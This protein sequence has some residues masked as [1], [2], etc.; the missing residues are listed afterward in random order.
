MTA[1]Q[2]IT[3]QHQL[4]QGTF[5]DI[6]AL[7]EAALNWDQEYDQIG[8]GQFRG[9]LTQLVF[10]QVQLNR[11]QWTTGVLQSGAAP[12]GTW[13][14]GLPLK[15]APKSFPAAM[16]ELIRRAVRKIWDARGG[17]FYACGFVVTFV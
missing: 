1:R 16:L 12:E 7:A 4:V 9:E 14:F 17:G 13:V 15:A 5:D 8:R 2:F 10:G 3:L 11:E 6:D